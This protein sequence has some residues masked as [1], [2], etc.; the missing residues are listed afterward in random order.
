MGQKVISREYKVMLRPQRFAGG[1]KALRRAAGAFWRDFGR[2]LDDDAVRAEGDLGER[3]EQRLIRFLDTPA[4]ALNAG[5]YI[6]RER[7]ALA[8]GDREMTLKFRHPDRHVAAA[9]DMAPDSGGKARTKFE[10]DI[11]APF[12]SLY[13]FSTTLPV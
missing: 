9:R 13:S 10:E 8:G 1:E 11:K 4:Q 5:S 6:F 2:A 12:I 7:R 3:K